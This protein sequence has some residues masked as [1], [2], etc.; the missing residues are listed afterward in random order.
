MQEEVTFEAIVSIQLGS[1]ASGDE[2][3]P[4]DQRHLNR[5]THE[6]VSIQ[7]GSP[8]SGDNG[9]NI[10]GMVKKNMMFPFN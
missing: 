5:G 6:E 8:A 2:E 7:L 9:I 4:Q 10:T 1:P 3:L